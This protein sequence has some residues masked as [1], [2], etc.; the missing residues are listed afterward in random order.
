[1]VR[2][3]PLKF[4]RNP[5]P[6]DAHNNPVQAKGGR[7]VANPYSPPLLPISGS[8]P[9]TPPKAGKPASPADLVSLVSLLPLN[10][11][12]EASR[13]AMYNWASIPGLDWHDQ[14]VGA[15]FW[16]LFPIDFDGADLTRESNWWALQDSLANY[17]Q[18]QARFLRFKHPSTSCM[19]VLAIQVSYGQ[20]ESLTPA[21]RLFYECVGKLQ[22]NEPIDEAVYREMWEDELKNSIRIAGSLYIRPGVA[23]ADVSGYGKYVA[24]WPTQVLRYLMDHQPEELVSVQGRIPVLKEGLVLNAMEKL[25]LMV[26]ELQPG[27]H[28]LQV[29]P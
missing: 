6:R 9:R 4:P 13:V 29:G 15:P 23:E 24:G 21:F 12:Q 17:L 18:W 1:M 28:D 10:D 11:V 22:K 7:K 8:P 16:C 2:K 19:R 26:P 27:L 14:P 3:K 5:D 20:V 25:H